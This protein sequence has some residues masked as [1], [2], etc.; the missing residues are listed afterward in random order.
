MYFLILK[1]FYFM[2]KTQI[3]PATGTY[4]DCS[5]P[6]YLS[7]KKVQCWIVYTKSMS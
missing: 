1:L 7:N 3:Q 2:T 6:S 4:E 5:S